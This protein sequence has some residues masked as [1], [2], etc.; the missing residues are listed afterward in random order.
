MKKFILGVLASVALLSAAPVTMSNNGSIV[1][2]SVVEA[3]TVKVKSIAQSKTPSK[4]YVGAKHSVKVTFNPKSPSNKSYTVSS[5][6][7]SVISVSGKTIVAKKTGTAVI[8]VTSKDGKKTAKKTVTVVA[9]VKKISQKNTPVLMGVGQRHSL[10]VAITPSNAYN[11]NYKVSTSN[12]AVVAVSGKTLVA[13]KAGTATIT[14]KAHNGKYSKV[15]IRVLKS[16]DKKWYKAAKGYVFAYDN[17]Q[18]GTKYMYHEVVNP[19]NYEWLT[20]SKARS[21]GFT[22]PYRNNGYAKW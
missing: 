4:M 9:P 21:K 19:M 14:V 22:E 5:N 3:A 13:K 2:P 15:T 6:K 8:T 10:E 18:T 17:Q 11:K 20:E 7:K 16:Y 1:N 12:S